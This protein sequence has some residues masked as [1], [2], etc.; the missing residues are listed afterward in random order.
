[1]NSTRYVHASFATKCDSNECHSNLCCNVN[2]QIW[3]LIDC[4]LV[5]KFIT[6]TCHQR[7]HQNRNHG[8]K[9]HLPDHY[10]PA[11]SLRKREP[12]SQFSFHKHAV[13]TNYL[14][15]GKFTNC[16]E[17]VCES[18]MFE[19]IHLNTIE[20]SQYL[21]M[22]S[23][24]YVKKWYFIETSQHKTQFSRDQKLDS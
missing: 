16:E 11:L 2:F 20:L 12:Q 23:K 17:L 5:S 3:D 24:M 10:P 19:P 8:S 4:N 15:E 18:H 14:R 7:E 22:G 9:V 6:A 13:G 21:T 1:M